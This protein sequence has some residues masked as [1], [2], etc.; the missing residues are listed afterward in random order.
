MASY[1]A[2]ET[3]AAPPDQDAQSKLSGA[4]K[5]MFLGQVSDASGI[6]PFRGEVE[7]G[8]AHLSEA[9]RIAREVIRKAKEQ[10]SFAQVTIDPAANTAVEGAQ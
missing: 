8:I 6:N 3:I 10:L 1:T 7:Y 9:L 4:W 2:A 5:L